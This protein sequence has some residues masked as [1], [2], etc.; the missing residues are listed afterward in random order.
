MTK[1]EFKSI[2]KIV[3]NAKWEL[4]RQGIAFDLNIRFPDGE[5]WHAGIGTAEQMC[6]LSV[7]SLFNLYRSAKKEDATPEQIFPA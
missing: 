2:F 1:R 3:D 6:E 4:F 5:C 7:R